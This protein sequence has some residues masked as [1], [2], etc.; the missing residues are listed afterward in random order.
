MVFR[1]VGTRHPVHQ[2]RREMDRLLSG[3]VGNV[4]D[5]NWPVVGRG[6]PAVNLW[7]TGDALKLELELPG[8]PSDQIELSVV[9]D[10]LSIRVE[11][12]DA[13]PQGATYHRRERGVGAFARAVRLPLEVDAERVEAE[14]R[15][16]VLTITL[17][18]AESARPRKIQVASG[19]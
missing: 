11:R 19:E 14:L 8:V 2:L 5:L 15:H 4:G 18:K 17:P 16:G 12:P 1:Y 9:G 13:E 3:F 7:E 10:E 6:R